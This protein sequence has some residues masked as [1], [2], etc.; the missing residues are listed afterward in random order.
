M[1][2]MDYMDPDVLCPQ[3]GCFARSLA[4]SL[5]HSLTHSLTHFQPVGLHTM[6]YVLDYFF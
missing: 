2:C 6:K 3:K 5:A 1:A 4:H